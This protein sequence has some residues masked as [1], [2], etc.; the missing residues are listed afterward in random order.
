MS[1]KQKQGKT[2]K[3]FNRITLTIVL[4]LF[5]LLLATMALTTAIMPFIASWWSVSEDNVIVFGVTI[6]AVSIVIG[7]GFSFAYSA[8]I[9]KATKPNLEALQKI[10]P[11]VSKTACCFRGSAWRKIS[12][13]WQTGWKAW[14]R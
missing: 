10:F 3:I 11:C 4:G 5:L 1:K 9:V 2:R 13:K 8:F 6:L 12:T 14:K 7:V